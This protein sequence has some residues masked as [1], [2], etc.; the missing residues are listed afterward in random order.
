MRFGTIGDNTIDLYVGAD[1]LSFVGGNA[2]NVAVQLAE[3][4]QDVAYFGA[5]G[6]DK[7]GARVRRAL[8]ER[9]V[10]VEHL[11]VISGVTST[12][13]V[14]VARNGERH[15]S[16]EDFGTSADYR[17]TS[18]ELDALAD[19][20]VVHIGWT[21]VAGQIRAALAG[22]GVVVAQD[23]A[24]AEGYDG[25]DVAFCS[26][27]E[28]RPEADR[29]ACEALAGGARLAVVTRGAAGSI[30]VD[31]ARSWS[32]D[33]VRVPVVDTTGAGDSFIAGFLAAFGGGATVEQAMRRGTDSAAQ[34][35]QH[36]G[37]FRQ[38]PGPGRE[39]V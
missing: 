27:G 22:R 10:G 14:E 17:P 15:L 13:L 33:A 5:V 19:C 26:A 25:V 9:G 4:G 28:A 37:G 35:C 8:A 12:S 36:R 32:Q 30:A 38:V 23:C 18:A 1:N 20:C 21:P 11:T 34:T 2:V 3:A 24:V 16:A 29:L 6:P 31:G 7:R 39:G